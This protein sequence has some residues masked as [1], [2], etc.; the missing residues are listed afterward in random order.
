M[1]TRSRIAVELSDGTVKSVYCHY[2]GYPEG[3]GQDLLNLEFSS[4]EEVE[5]FIDEG[6]RSTVEL[7]YKE[8]R[9]EDCPPDSH[10]S[11]RDFFDGDIEMY[12]Y[13]FTQEGEWLVWSHYS[14]Q[15]MPMRLEEVL[16]PQFK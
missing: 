11:V 5:E 13:L 10:E 14:G 6:D 16:S 9:D 1:A 7:S 8:W 2:D 15:S 12:G 4:T 3:V